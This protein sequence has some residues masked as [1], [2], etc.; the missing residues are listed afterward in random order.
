MANFIA[1][2]L[3]RL[4]EGSTWAVIFGVLVGTIGLKIPEDLWGYITALGAAAAG[5]L[6]FLLRDTGAKV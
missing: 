1:F 2:L 6:G 5:L 4:K 3:A